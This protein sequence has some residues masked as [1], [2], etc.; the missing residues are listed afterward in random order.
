MDNYIKAV[1]EIGFVKDKQQHGEHHISFHQKGVEL[2]LQKLFDEV[3]IFTEKNRHIYNAIITASKEYTIYS[4][5][6]PQLPLAI[7]AIVR[8]WAKNGVKLGK[9]KK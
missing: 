1:E 5:E 6:E 3:S 4:I 8:F 9:E 7:R 2:V